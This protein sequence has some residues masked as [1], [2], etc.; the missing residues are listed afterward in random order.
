MYPNFGTPMMVMTPMGPMMMGQPQMPTMNPMVMN[1]MGGSPIALMNMNSAMN[2]PFS[3]IQQVQMTTAQ[4]NPAVASQAGGVAASGE[5][6]GIGDK[7][8]AADPAE[9]AQAV[10]PMTLVATPFG[11]YAVQA[12]ADM[13]AQL[14]QMQVPPQQQMGM[15]TMNPYMGNPYMGIY[16]SPY[17][18]VAMNPA[19]ANPMGAFAG[20]QGGM[21]V[22]EMIMIMTF[23]NNNNKPHQR[24]ARL[25]DR[26]AERREQ[27]QANAGSDPFAQLMQAWSTPYVSPDTTLRMPSRSAYPY[28]YF[29]VQAS[30]VSTA[31]YG[32]YHNLSFGSTAYPGLY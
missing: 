6:P 1:Q 10:Q 7:P 20:G 31:N 16:A 15:G 29:G 30:P 5:I 8:Q 3:Q 28:G 4:A 21:S 9:N 22:S 14:A 18:Y 32:G 13:N 2:S 17:G 23:L 26:L 25:M 27:R 19:A 11:Y 24:R 12:S